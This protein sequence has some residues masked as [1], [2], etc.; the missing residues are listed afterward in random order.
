M[1]RLGCHRFGDRIGWSLAFSLV[2][3]TI[4][5][6]SG[7]FIGEHL[8]SGTLMP[9]IQA[10]AKAQVY[11]ALFFGQRFL[12]NLSVDSFFALLIIRFFSLYF[13]FQAF[14]FTPPMLVLH[15]IRALLA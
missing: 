8:R 2:D 3:V 6:V 10:L 4:W 11:V 7:S 14:L 13:F 12:M 9:F 1:D 15:R 5:F